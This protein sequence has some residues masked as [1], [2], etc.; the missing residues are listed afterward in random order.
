MSRA[1]SR[2]H[3]LWAIYSSQCSCW[4]SDTTLQIF[5]VPNIRL[6]VRQQQQ[7]HFNKGILCSELWWNSDIGCLIL[8][9]QNRSVR[10]ERK[11]W[12]TDRYPTNLCIFPLCEPKCSQYFPR[13]KVVLRSCA[14]NCH[15]KKR[16][17]HRPAVRQVSM[18]THQISCV[19]T[20]FLF[21]TNSHMEKIRHT[22]KLKQ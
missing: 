8:L 10:I 7:P 17:H 15:R 3:C 13:F 18:A 14:V 4:T 19:I 1:P 6:W 21:H 9:Q 5:L 12:Q 22:L 11:E 2:T 16:T 20:S